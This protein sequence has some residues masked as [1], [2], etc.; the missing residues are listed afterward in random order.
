M[1]GTV[2]GTG[3]T[4]TQSTW[5]ALLCHEAERQAHMMSFVGEEEDSAIVLIN[6]LSKVRGDSVQIRFSPTD[7]SHDGF[8]EGETIRGRELSVTFNTDSLKINWLAEAYAEQGPMTQ[9]R[10][11]FDIKATSFYKLKTW[12]SRRFEESLLNQLGGNTVASTGLFKRVGMN[13][14]P[15]TDN[16]HKVYGGGLTTDD[17]VG[18]DTTAI[19]TLDL[20]DDCVLKAQSK[21]ELSYPIATCSDGWY[22]M[23][24]HPYQWKQLRQ[25]TTSGQWEDITRAVLEGGKSYEKSAFNRGWLGSWNNTK[26]HVSDYVPNGVEDSDSTTAVGTCRRAVFL[27]AKAAHIA[28]GEDFAGGDHLSW[29]EQVDDYVVF[30]ILAGSVLGMKTTRFNNSS[31]TAENYGCIVVPTYA[32]S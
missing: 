15:T 7:D 32:T 3:N 12:W 2:I 17:L 8:G 6:D 21:S 25:N 23:V 24:V 10:V 11:N 4:L 9:Q 16:N 26:I 20:I 18:A 5:R 27:G 22:H 19:M 13:A 31:G 30:G 29:I 1:A 14:V 28:F